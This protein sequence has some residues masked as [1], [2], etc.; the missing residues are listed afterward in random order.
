MPRATP[1]ACGC[2]TGGNA[3]EVAA[4]VGLT[5]V[6]ALLLAALLLINWW[7]RHRDA[8]LARLTL[9]DLMHAENRLELVACLEALP[10]LHAGEA[11]R[12]RDM[13]IL[14]A[15]AGA[16]SPDWDPAPRPSARRLPVR[17]PTG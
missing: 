12:V 10:S 8:R 5:A 7:H 3:P 15:A 16:S 4:L 11:D 17:R 1:G 6:A 14:S 13:L 9:D 2:C